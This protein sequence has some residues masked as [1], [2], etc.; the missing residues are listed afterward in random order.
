MFIQSLSQ[1]MD[2]VAAKQELLGTTIDR[3]KCKGEPALLYAQPRGFSTSLAL[4]VP[5]VQS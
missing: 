1:P 3:I 2:V 4:I 5:L